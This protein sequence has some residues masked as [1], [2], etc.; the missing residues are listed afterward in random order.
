MAVLLNIL[1]EAQ[2]KH[3]YLSEEALKEI[4]VKHNVPI[5]RLYATASFYTMLK[6]EPQGKHT[7]EVCTGPSC[8][9]NNGQEV[10][11]SIEKELGIRPGNTT[12]D[13]KCSYYKTSCI[14][15]CNEAPAM[16]LD[17][18]PETRLTEKKISSIIRRIRDDK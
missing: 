10:E 2:D 14:G 15:F 16:L 17:Q 8:I 9:L 13:G 18:K 7:I 5:A 6:L 11:S 12:K 3:G 1:R 4:S